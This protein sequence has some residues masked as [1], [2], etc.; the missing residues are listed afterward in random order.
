MTKE[1]LIK[2]LEKNGAVIEDGTFAVGDSRISVDQL[3]SAI[4]YLQNGL[5]SFA[6]KF[7]DAFA[8]SAEGLSAYVAKAVKEAEDGID[9]G[10]KSAVEKWNL[11]QEIKKEDADGS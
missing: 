2:V 5:L 4:E 1:E 7:I 6:K 10:F 3:H 9:G 8:K 11:V